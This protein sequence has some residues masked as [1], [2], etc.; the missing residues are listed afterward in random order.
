MILSTTAF[1]EAEWANSSSKKY[2]RLAQSGRSHVPILVFAGCGDGRDGDTEC[3]NGGRRAKKRQADQLSSA[4]KDRST[5]HMDTEEGRQAKRLVFPPLAGDGFLSGK[6]ETRKF[7][8]PANRYTLLKENWMKIFT[9]VVEHLGLQIR[10]NLKSRNVEIRTCKETKDVSAL[11]KAADFVKAFILGFQVEDAL[12]L[13]RL[14]DLFLETFEITDVKPLKGDHLSRAIGRTAG[15]G[16]KT[17]FTIEN[18]TRTRVVLA[19]VKVHILG[20]FQNIK[21]ARTGICNLILG[22]PPSK[23]YGNIQAVASRSAKRF[24]FHIRDFLSFPMMSPKCLVPFKASGSEL[25][26]Q[27]KMLTIKAK[28]ELLHMLKEGKSYAAIG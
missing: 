8:V 3:H 13:I 19:D 5:G 6:E 11:I 10:F 15:K 24:L 27:R 25:K 20:F 2:S 17:K 22:N 7:S 9:P 26:R 12:A 23:V 18:V 14:D 1:Q 21:I 16:G 4:G 28:V